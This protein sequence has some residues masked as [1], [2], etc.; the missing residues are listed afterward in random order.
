MQSWAYLKDSMM[1][2]ILSSEHELSSLKNGFLEI[3]GISPKTQNALGHLQ[4]K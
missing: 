4:H 1:I 2:F 3:K